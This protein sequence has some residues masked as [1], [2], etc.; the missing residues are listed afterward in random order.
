M[1]ILDIPNEL[2]VLIGEELAIKDLAKFFLACRRLKFLLTPRLYKLGLQDVGEI[3][4]LQWAA[5]RGHASLAERAI[6]AGAEI[7]KP[8]PQQSDQ[9]PL[10]SAA[11]NNHHDVVRIL[12]K[13]KATISALDSNRRTPLHYAATCEGEEAT[14]ELLNAGADMRCED[15]LGNTPP[16]LAARDGVVASMRAFVDA[17]FGLTT[18]GDRGQTILHG[19]IGRRR[20][21]GYLLGRTEAKTVVNLQTFD[22]ATPMHWEWDSQNVKLLLHYGA[23]IE[24]KDRKG[25]TPA[26]KIAGSRNTCSMRALLDAGFNFNTRGRCGRTVLHSAVRNHEPVMLEYLLLHA[27]RMGIIDAQDSD[28]RTPLDLAIREFRLWGLPSTLAQVNLLVHYGSDLELKDSRGARLADIVQEIREKETR[29]GNN[30]GWKEML[31]TP[32][33]PVD[34]SVQIFGR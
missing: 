5:G 2:I 34:E 27:R 33:F 12:I 20:M 6:L 8:D 19:A 3:T 18:P 28:G 14:I 13:N 15:V 9:T 25:D 1:N 32:R 16:F 21:M 26:H 10:H 7:D 24:L 4:A 31:N 29:R 23:D 11:K 22:G 30:E 17:G